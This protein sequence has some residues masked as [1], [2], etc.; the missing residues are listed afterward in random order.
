[1]VVS[2]RSVVG[3]PFSVVGW[4]KDSVKGENRHGNNTVREVYTHRVRGHFLRPTSLPTLKFD[5]PRLGFFS[6]VGWVLVVIE[7]LFCGR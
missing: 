1:M 2:G 7:V 4:V 6:L 5:V 3:R